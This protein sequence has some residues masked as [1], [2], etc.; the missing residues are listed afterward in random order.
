[1]QLFVDTNVLLS[2]YHFTSDELEELKKLVVLLEQK[3]VQLHVPDQ[4]V[5]EFQRNR[6][7]KIADAL[8]R[9][10][11][12]VVNLQFPQICK[13]YDEYDS[14]RKLQELFEARHAT[15]LNKL[16]EDVKH[17]ALKADQII[18]QLIELSNRIACSA[19]IIGD[20]RQRVDLGN[21]PGKKGA[22]GDAVN[23]EA[24]LSG[25]PD[26][27][28][29]HFITDDKDYVSPLDDEAFN[30]FLLEEWGKRKKSGLIFYKRLSGFFK[31][32][33]PEIKFAAELEKELLIEALA[34]SGTFARTHAVIAKL[35]KYADFTP[36]QISAIV[37]A[38]ITNS[39]I[40]SIIGD[41]DVHSFLEGLVK[42]AEKYIDED[43]LVEIQDL[44][45]SPKNAVVWD[46]DDSF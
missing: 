36:D 14:L 39:Q 15:L 25:V 42:G 11:E 12:Q 5:S 7:A 22:L 33:F 34:H 43:N 16:S 45:Q 35:S 2:F 30:G 8:K 41:D 38:S 3:K 23:W 13:D 24:L 44:L 20:A 31:E 27:R 1:M 29:L 18:A 28:D 10:R 21:P 9:L 4:V 17:Y 19:Q 37:A 46:D 26:K 40:S 6:E 32:H